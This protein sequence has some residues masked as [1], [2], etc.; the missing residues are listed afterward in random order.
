[1]DTR[2]DTRVVRV[3]VSPAALGLRA[4]IEMLWAEIE[5][6]TLY[7]LSPEETALLKTLLRRV[8]ANLDRANDRDC[9]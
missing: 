4:R 2:L 7:G 6:A 1:M 3:H 5:A 9:P 8:C